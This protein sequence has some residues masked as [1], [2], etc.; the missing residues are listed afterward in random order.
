M[1]EIGNLKGPFDFWPGSCPV[2]LREASRKNLTSCHGIRR[3]ALARVYANRSTSSAQS[4][5]YTTGL[6]IQ[7]QQ[8]NGP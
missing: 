3:L 4:A 5:Q 1:L 7:M 2:T 6:K 8:V